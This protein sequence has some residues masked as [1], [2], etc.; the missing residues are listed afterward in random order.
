MSTRAIKYIYYHIV[1]PPMLP[2]HNETEA[3]DQEEPLERE[4]YRLVSSTLED[5]ASNCPPESTGPWNITINM[6]NL[7]MSTVKGGTL[8]EDTLRDA[9]SNIRVHGIVILPFFQDLTDISEQGLWRF[10]SGLRTAAGW[11]TMTRLATS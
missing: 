3:S 2:Q 9:L 11:P 10:T 8:C 7:W 1:H 6:L 5:F 4:L